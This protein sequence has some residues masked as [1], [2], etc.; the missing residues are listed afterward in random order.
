[1]ASG[2]AETIDFAVN[3]APYFIFFTNLLKKDRLGSS[4]GLCRLSLLSTS[5]AK[6]ITVVVLDAAVSY[7]IAAYHCSVDFLMELAIIRNFS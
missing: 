5:L 1:M 4:R 3:T 2:M 6:Y 7:I